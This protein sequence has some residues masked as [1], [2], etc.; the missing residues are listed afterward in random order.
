MK[1]SRD[2][3]GNR[4]RD[5]PATKKNTGD[6]TNTQCYILIILVKFREI[7]QF[8]KTYFSNCPRWF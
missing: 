8:T 4:T 2:A 5:L 1:H 7:S 6:V 3:I